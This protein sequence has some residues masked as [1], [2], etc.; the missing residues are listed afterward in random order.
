[1]DYGDL[2]SMQDFLNQ[3]FSIA[4]LYDYLE[5]L[6]LDGHSCAKTLAQLQQDYDA[7][8]CESVVEL[9]ND[10][11]NDDFWCNEIELEVD[12]VDSGSIVIK[13]VN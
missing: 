2:L 10:I 1:M 8:L 13:A 3:Q 12:G 7:Y 5:E 11:Y 6:A 9:F 4:N